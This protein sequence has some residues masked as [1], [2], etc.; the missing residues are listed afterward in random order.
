MNYVYVLHTYMCTHNIR[1]IVYMC[2]T[3]ILV[4]LNWM[5]LHIHDKVVHDGR[6][7]ARRSW[8]KSWTRPGRL[9]GGFSCLICLL[10][11]FWMTL[12]QRFLGYQGTTRTQDDNWSFIAFFSFLDCLDQISWAKA[13]RTHLLRSLDPHRVSYENEVRRESSIQ[14]DLITHK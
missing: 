7:S 6:Q 8:K 3:S 13:L 2:V 14:K 1:H 5:P 11:R 9:S 10:Y 4:F 12:E